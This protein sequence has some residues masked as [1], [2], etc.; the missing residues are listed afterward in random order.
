MGHGRD[1][2]LVRINKCKNLSSDFREETE[3][4]KFKQDTLN[5][6]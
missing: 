1:H 4:F 3:K 2:R 5:E 6:L